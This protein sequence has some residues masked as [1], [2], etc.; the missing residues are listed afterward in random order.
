VSD[1]P[2]PTQSLRVALSIQ[3]AIAAV[4]MIVVAVSGGSVAKALGTAALYFVLVGGWSWF[5]IWRADRE[6]KRGSAEER[7]Q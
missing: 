5:R 6:R 1:L 3:A 2:P 7:P 4:I